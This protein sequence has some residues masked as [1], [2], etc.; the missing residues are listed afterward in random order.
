M[1]RKEKLKQ[2]RL[3]TTIYNLKHVHLKTEPT[4]KQKD[5]FMR[6]LGQTIN[7]D[8]FKAVGYDFDPKCCELVFDYIKTNT[9]ITKI[10]L[11]NNPLGD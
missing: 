6:K 4:T 1:Q 5:R 8:I 7:E 3:Y 11:D 9:S 2:N 10:I